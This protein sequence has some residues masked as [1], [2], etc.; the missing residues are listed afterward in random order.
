MLSIE[1]TPAEQLSFIVIN[2]AVQQTWPFPE[3][4]FILVVSDFFLGAQWMSNFLF[5]WLINVIDC[6]FDWLINVIDCL[7][8]CFFMYHT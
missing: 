8:G 1:I 4:S 2:N 6:F 5:D 3:C 7:F